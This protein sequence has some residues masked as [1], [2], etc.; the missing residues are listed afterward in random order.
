MAERD[1]FEL[2]LAAALRAYA[3]D[4]PTQAR[5]TEL[6][7]QFAAAYPHRRT[8]I[9]RWGF[10]LTPALAWAL[11]LAALLAAMVAGMLVGSQLQQKLPAVVPTQ[12]PA[13]HA[14]ALAPTGIDV[15]TSDPGAYGRIVEDGAGILWAREDGG[16]LVRFDPASG[17]ARAWTVTDDAAFETTDIAPARD[18]GVWLLNGWTLRRFDGPVFGD[19]AD[20]ARAWRRT[21][22]GRSVREAGDASE[23]S[24]RNGARAQAPESCSA[25]VV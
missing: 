2:D 20:I 22:A 4:A 12:R 23:A 10:G 11:L 24:S 14:A 9:G 17:T 7:R 18:G 19:V 25:T 6:V 3:E 15:L 16:R 1:R 5:P 8:S 13:P 21:A